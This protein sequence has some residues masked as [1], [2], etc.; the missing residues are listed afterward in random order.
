MEDNGTTENMKTIT[1][2]EPS[3]NS[4]LGWKPLVMLSRVSMANMHSFA[5]MSVFD[6]V[7]YAPYVE[8]LGLDMARKCT[9]DDALCDELEINY[10][11]P[12]HPE[13]AAY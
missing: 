5:F 13:T 8:A 7:L 2:L 6:V 9:R 10:P 4:S 12:Q 3:P 11:I 1:S